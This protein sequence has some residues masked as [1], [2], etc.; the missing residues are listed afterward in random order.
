MTLSIDYVLHIY[1]NLMCTDIL[2]SNRIFKKKLIFK[3]DIMK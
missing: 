2:Y 1:L 3:K